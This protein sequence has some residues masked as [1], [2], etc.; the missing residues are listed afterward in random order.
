VTNHLHRALLPL[1]FTIT[2]RK[3]HGKSG[4][5]V[6]KLFDQEMTDNILGQFIIGNGLPLRLVESENF[7]Q[8]VSY[9]RPCYK[10][11]FAQKTNNGAS[12]RDSGRDRGGDERENVLYQ[13]TI[14]S[15][16][17][18]GLPRRT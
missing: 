3:K 12:C 10:P 9:L 17:I 5:P 7:K 18:L 8:F 13:N 16:W 4:R 11:L 14:P 6:D 15:R 2:L 1:P